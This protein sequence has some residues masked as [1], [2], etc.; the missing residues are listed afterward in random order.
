[1][2]GLQTCLNNG[3]VRSKRQ[4]DNVDSTSIFKDSNLVHADSGI[5]ERLT[6]G[7]LPSRFAALS[8]RIPGRAEDLLDVRSAD[9]RDKADRLPNY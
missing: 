8:K 2:V 3:L 4:I 1:M 7:D 6:F 5:A 9:E